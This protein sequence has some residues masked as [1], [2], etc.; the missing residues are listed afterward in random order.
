MTEITIN[1]VKYTNVPNKKAGTKFASAL[2]Q[3]NIGISQSVADYMNSAYFYTLVNAVDINW[4]G[5]EVAANSYINTTSDLIKFILSVSNIDL[6]DYATMSYVNEKISDVIGAAP[7]TLDTLEELAYALSYNVSLSYVQEALSGKANV[8][9]VYTKTEVDNLIPDPVDLSSYATTSYVTTELDKKADKTDIVQA[10]MC[11]TDTTSKSYVLNN[12]YQYHVKSEYGTDYNCYNLVIPHNAK[13][14]FFSDFTDN[15]LVIGDDHYIKGS[16]GIIQGKGNRINNI[17]EAAFGKF[18]ECDTSWNPTIF[19]VGNGTA[20]IKHNA[21]AIRKNG[22]IYIADTEAGTP[23]SL[24]S[25]LNSKAN[26]KD[27]YTKTE[28]DNMIPESGNLSNYVSYTQANSYY[29]TVEGAKQLIYGS[30]TFIGDKKINF[31]QGTPANK[32]GFTLYDIN[33]KEV[34][35]LEW[36]P[37]TIGGRSLLSL[38]QYIGTGNKFEG[39]NMGYLGFRLKES[40]SNSKYHLITPLPSY[41]N[42][43]E[44]INVDNDYRNFF[45]PLVFKNGINKVYTECTGLVDL[46]SLIPSA[47]DLSGYVSYTQANSYY[48]AKNDIPT[49]PDM[50]SYV[51]LTSYNALVARVEELA[52]WIVSYHSS[53]TPTPSGTDPDIYFDSS[54]LTVD[55]QMEPNK[56]NGTEI[57]QGLSGN[58]AH[59]SAWIMWS[60]DNSSIATVNH[61]GYVIAQGNGTVNIIAEYG[62]HDN[63][64]SKTVQYNLTITNYNAKQNPTGGWYENS[65]QVLN[66]DLVEGNTSDKTLTFS[67]TPNDSWSFG[68]PGMPG[69]SVNTTTGEI[70]ITGANVQSSEGPVSASRMEDASY[71]SGNLSLNIKVFPVGTDLNFHYDQLSVNLDNQGMTTITPVLTNYT[72]I[73]T[74]LYPIQYVSGDTNVATV[75]AYGMISFA[76]EGTTTITATLSDG[77]ENHTATI[78]VY[79]TVNKQYPYA[80]FEYNGTPYSGGTLPVVAPFTGTIQLTN[81]TPSNG[82]VIT[83]PMIQGITVLQNVIEVQDLPQGTYYINANRA[84]DSD[85]YPGM[86]SLT[87]RVLPSGTNPNFFYE[88]ESV[89]LDNQAMSQSTPMLYNNTGFEAMATYQSADT[90]IATVNENGMISFVSA[91]TTTVT[92]SIT[93]GTDTYTTSITVN[94]NVINA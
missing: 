4:N 82:W 68:D 23:Y 72:A 75:D 15:T 73:D 69:V 26:T 45:F 63:Y 88:Q 12:P 55:Y 37:D 44:T 87:L 8:N 76:G 59:S 11:E 50:S 17:F 48:A 86:T 80:S 36:R 71:Y 58:D 19:T 29:I 9:D 2:T 16:Y 84:E 5:I 38:Q 14:Q 77:N 91:G 3:S 21:F 33:E 34:G 79:C 18:N 67:A 43:I 85:Y 90:T 92:A 74:T 64:N 56:L 25:R 20:S 62:A 39:V 70:T 78:T 83:D 30:K 40:S 60:T 7:E 6:S 10:D 13:Q 24:Q 35:G 93:N 54:E 1:D 94:C 31:R 28:V 61:G 53:Y 81:M 41:V 46:S 47:P 52:G 65:S 27:V 49:M 57:T 51:S 89:S 32:L 42:N 22:I 66:L